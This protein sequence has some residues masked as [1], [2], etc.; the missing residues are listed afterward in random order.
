MLRN[1]LFLP[2]LL[3]LSII[4]YFPVPLKREENGDNAMCHT[5]GTIKHMHLF[6]H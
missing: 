6:V 5:I 4:H 2:T 1:I 3:Q